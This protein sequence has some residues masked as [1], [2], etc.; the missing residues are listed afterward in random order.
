MSVVLNDLESRLNEVHQDVVKWRRY[1]HENPELSFEEVATSQFVYDTLLTFQNLEISRPTKTSVMARLKGAHPG[2]VIALRADMDALPIHEENE[3]SF[4]SKTPGKMHACG[5]DGHTAVLLGVAKV[6]SQMQSSL[7]G[8]VRFLFQHAEE[9]FPGGAQEMVHA[10]V[11]DGVDLVLG[12]HLWAG[13]HV[14]TIA[15]RSGPLMA[16]PDTF[17]ITIVGKGGHAAIPQQTVDSIAVGAQ[18]VT[19][20]QHIV[21]R[22]VDPLTPI[23]VS[24]TTFIA[25]TADNV[26]P[27]VAELTGT[28]RTFD[29]SLRKEA[30]ILMERIIKGV[31]EAHGATYQFAYKNGYRPVINDAEVTAVLESCLIETFGEDVVQTAEQTMGGEDFCAYQQVAPGT[32]FFIGAGNP[33]EGIIAPHHHP[34]FTVDERSLPMGVK[35]FVATVL[36]LLTQ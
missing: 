11:L 24:V 23:V 36:K 12:A 5:H 2:K 29:E 18:V 1:L 13:L 20:L 32:F 21:S 8:E 28:V 3:F 9:L 7:S 30:P 31:T 15:V 17:R 10:G 34:R 26:I 4:I 22:A 33:E 14:G 19:N 35:A 25:G 27:E 6:V 16:A